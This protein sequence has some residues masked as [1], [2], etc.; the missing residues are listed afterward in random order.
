LA[1]IAVAR[2]IDSEAK[3]YPFPHIQLEN[4]VMEI[5]SKIVRQKIR[6]GRDWESLVLPW[7]RGI[8]ERRQLYGYSGDVRMRKLSQSVSEL[9]NKNC[10]L[11]L[12]P[13]STQKYKRIWQ[14][15]IPK[16]EAAAHETLNT[17]RFLHS[18]H[19][20]IQA[21]DLCSRFGLDPVEGYLAGIA[22]DLAKQLDSKKIL[23]LIKSE[24]IKPSKIEKDKPSL[25]HGKAGAVLLRERFYIHNKEVLEAV[26]FHTSGN[27][28]MGALAKVIYI[29]DKTESSRNIDPALKKMY[30]QA[31]LDTI[32]YEK[33]KK[34]IF[35]LRAKNLVLFEDTLKLL[36]KIKEKKN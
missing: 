3:K 15:G 1:D 29:A 13:P 10:T 21:Y 26:A 2:R 7:T 33:K 22:H 12:F 18:R 11:D 32:L 14:A 23:K 25:L 9:W 28:N 20:A 17:E 34:N 19:T 4:D 31:D 30:K 5:S 35:K 8:I 16:I 27:E 6:E 36:A 24:G